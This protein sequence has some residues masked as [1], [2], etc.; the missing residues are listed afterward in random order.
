MKPTTGNFYITI[1][2]CFMETVFKSASY[3][4]VLNDISERFDKITLKELGNAQLMNRTDT[5]FLL[6]VHQLPFLLEQLHLNYR[7]MEVDGVLRCPYQT[8]YY[9]TQDLALYQ[10]HLT[11]RSNRCKIRQRHYAQSNLTFTEVKRKNAKNRTEK[12]RVKC[13]VWTFN[14]TLEV[15]SQL[16]DET[17]QTFIEEVTGGLSRQINPSDLKPVLWVAYNRI[18]FVNATQNERLTIDLD[19]TFK[20]NSMQVNFSDLIIVE[21]K[22]GEREASHFLDLARRKNWREGGVS[23]YCLGLISLDASLRHNRFKPKLRYLSK[24]LNRTI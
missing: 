15:A 4:D 8:V 6:P 16:L 17:S 5:K 20:N 24:V 2:I 18:T 9:D 7:W 3:P 22:R 19:L 21:V 12:Y 13:P 11:G 1:A 14:H 23:K 10:A